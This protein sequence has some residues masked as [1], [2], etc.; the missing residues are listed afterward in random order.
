MYSQN[1][2][3]H[4]PIHCSGW[5]DI[6]ESHLQLPFHLLDFHSLLPIMPAFSQFHWTY[7][8]Y[9]WELDIHLF[10]LQNLDRNMFPELIFLMFHPSFVWYSCFSL[11]FKSAMIGSS[12]SQV[13]KIL[14]S[15]RFLLHWYR[16]YG[17]LSSQ[18][19]KVCLLPPWGREVLQIFST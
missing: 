3:I 13:A 19:F 5:I 17:R 15:W 18:F 8:L 12:N 4:N 16:I 7:F 11:I 9:L 10:T 14:H 1:Y 2:I 6:W